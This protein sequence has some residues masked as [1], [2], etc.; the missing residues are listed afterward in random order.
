VPKVTVVDIS[1]VVTSVTVVVV[2]VEDVVT[3]PRMIVGTVTVVLGV[4]TKQEHPS[5]TADVGKLC[6]SMFSDPFDN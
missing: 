3:P 1:R 4:V 5:D 6:K 2:V